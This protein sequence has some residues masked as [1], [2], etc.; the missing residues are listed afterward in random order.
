M[1]LILSG[2][3]LYC[4]RA[5]KA[6]LVPKL[7]ATTIEENTRIGRCSSESALRLDAFSVLGVRLTQLW[8]QDV[9]YQHAYNYRDTLKDPSADLYM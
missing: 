4:F 6:T 3:S 2:C 8:I 1:L 7:E 9:L 5:S